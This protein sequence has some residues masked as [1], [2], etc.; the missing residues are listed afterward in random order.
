M[1]ISRPKQSA[2]DALFLGRGIY[3][4][5]EVASLVKRDP[6]TIDRWTGGRTPLHRVATKPLYVFLDVISLWVVSEL[7]GRKVPKKEIRSG[8]DY[9]AKELE[10]SFP[11]AHQAL[12]TVGAAVFGNLGE[13]VDVGKRGQMAFQVAIKAYLKPL[14]YGPD[15]LA[16]VWRPVEGVWINPEVQAGAP[17]IEGT[18]IPTRT[19]FAL[20]EADEDVE[21]VA[22][23]YDLEVASV[24]AAVAFEQAA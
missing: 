17:C 22:A 15:G 7:V 1:N 4:V 5:V 14:E 9:L 21:D 3:D 8:A 12:A 19:L 20:V 10:T 24:E 2:S 6:E 11:L 23:D 13:W 18:R 16:S